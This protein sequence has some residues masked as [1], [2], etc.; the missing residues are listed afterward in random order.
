MISAQNAQNNKKMLST[1]DIQDNCAQDNRHPD[2][3]Q[4]RNKD[5]ENEHDRDADLAPS[6]LPLGLDAV[7]DEQDDRQ[8]HEALDKDRETRC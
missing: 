5:G 1:H 3:R 4:H 7:N 2:K 6:V 8:Y